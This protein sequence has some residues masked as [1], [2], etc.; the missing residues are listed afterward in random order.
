MAKEDFKLT[1]GVWV[2]NAGLRASVNRLGQPF[3]L[4]LVV[5]APNREYLTALVY[6]NV[7]VLRSH[8]EDLGHAALDDAG[9]L[10]SDAVVSLFRDIF[11]RHNLAEPG[12]SRRFERFVLLNE[13]PQIDRNETTD[14]GYINQSAVLR[15]HAGLVEAL[16]SDPPAAGVITV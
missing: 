13:L 15:S 8:F 16:Y 3:L 4:D 11:R 9:F 14:K 1:S 12:S 2:H 7:A 5:A 10:T 6:P